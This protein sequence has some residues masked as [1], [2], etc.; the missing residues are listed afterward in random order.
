MT[1]NLAF[2]YGYCG[3]CEGTGRVSH[4]SHI[5]GG[6]C[7]TCHGTGRV[8]ETSPDVAPAATIE[9]LR[10]LFATWR[11]EQRRGHE[12]DTVYGFHFALYQLASDD[13]ALMTRVL[14]AIAAIDAHS[15]AYVARDLCELRFFKNLDGRV[16]RLV[17]ER[18]L[19]VGGKRGPWTWGRKSMEPVTGEWSFND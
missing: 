4:Y 1:T 12:T 9:G 8:R 16:Q 2:G 11:N 18:A 7:F 17:M 3:K 13:V 15:A 6:A 5:A 14:D 10:A 19:P